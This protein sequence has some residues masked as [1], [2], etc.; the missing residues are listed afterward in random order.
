MIRLALQEKK[1]YT[2]S[3]VEADLPAPT[4][5][6]D[7]LR[8]LCRQFAA[9]TEFFFLTGLDAF[10][11]IRTWKAF[12]ELLKI[13]SFVV[14]AR[15]GDFSEVKERLARNLGY[16][17]QGLIWQSNDEKKPVIILDRPPFAISSS[18]IRQKIRAGH[19]V[20]G[21][22]PDDVLAYILKHKLYSGD[23]KSTGQ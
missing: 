19:S 2:F 23:D 8:Y 4:Y 13:V 15:A 12:E 18:D 14:S 21:L 22:V 6:V 17:P 1:M 3:L 7:T 5:T 10:L 9:G 20:K 11:E 16:S